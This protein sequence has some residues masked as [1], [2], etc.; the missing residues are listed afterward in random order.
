MSATSV[1]FATNDRHHVID[2]DPDPSVFQT[3]V[4]V[5]ITHE[6][7]DSRMYT[8]ADRWARIIQERKPDK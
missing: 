8:A 7:F 3:F 1:L 2:A 6:E 4:H 5:I